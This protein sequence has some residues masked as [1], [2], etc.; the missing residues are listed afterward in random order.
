MNEA[1]LIDRTVQGD[2][3]AFNDLVL[4]YQDIAYNTAYRI[5]ADS[6]AAADATQEA[7]ISMYRKLDGYRGGSFKS[8]FLRIV[9]NA[10]YDE[11]RRQ[12]RRPT[13]PLEPVNPEDGEEMES[14]EWLRSDEPQPEEAFDTAE[15]EHALQ[16]AT[17]EMLR[18]LTAEYGLTVN[19]ASML[20]GQCVEYD[21]GNIFDPAY[22]M[23]CRLAK[24]YLPAAGSQGR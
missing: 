5:M 14:A 10:C 7:V 13:T 4:L 23:V 12:K 2:L 1:D 24:K 19:E 18:W 8:W 21:L 6:S 9:T 22:T 20:L 11:L 16:H 17:T 15:L 3:D